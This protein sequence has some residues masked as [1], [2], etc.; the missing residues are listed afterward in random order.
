MAFSLYIGIDLGGWRGKTTAVATM[1]PSGEAVAVLY[2][3]AR[4]KEGAP[5]GDEALVAFLTEK[6]TQYS[7]ILVAINGPL[8]FPACTRCQIPVCPSVQ[9]CVDPAVLWLRDFEESL[10]HSQD[11][12]GLV[13]TIASG[14]KRTFNRGRKIREH[15]KRCVPYLHRCTEIEAH[16][17]KELIPVDY[18]GKSNSP[19]GT[20]AN[21]LVK[22]LRGHGFE[23]HKNLIE[24]SSRATV[25]ALCGSAKARGYKRDADPWHTRAAILEGFEELKFSPSSRFAR[26]DTLSNDHCFEALL[27]AYAASL[28]AREGMSEV[29]TPFDKDGFLFVPQKRT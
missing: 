12:V 13:E 7:E 10:R 5:W 16:F 20:R 9:N 14:K 1:E 25:E 23:I 15:Q 2:V 19:I 29:S 17:H 24:V 28:I 3:G 21:H 27:S 11:S 8:T 22:A 4:E 6:K 26:E 18:I